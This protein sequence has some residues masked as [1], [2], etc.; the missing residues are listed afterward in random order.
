MSLSKRIKSIIIISLISVAVIC[1]YYLV[2]YF[3]HGTSNDSYYKFTDDELAQLKDIDKIEIYMLQPEYMFYA[4]TEDSESEE[5]KG[6][7]FPS[8]CF[9]F[10]QT[11]TC[12]VHEKSRSAQPRLFIPVHIFL[13]CF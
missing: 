13:S 3:L 8:A 6:F 5:K 4:E 2:N 7:S 12:I 9:A 1:G 10:P 11:H